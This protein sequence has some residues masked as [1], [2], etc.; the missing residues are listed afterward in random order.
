[1]QI[2]WGGALQHCGVRQTTLHREVEERDGERKL[3]RA[4]HNEKTG[5]SKNKTV[6]FLQDNPNQELHS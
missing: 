3:D 1:M 6:Q 5:F 4:P 2:K